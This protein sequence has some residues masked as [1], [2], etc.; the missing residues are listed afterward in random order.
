MLSVTELYSL[1]VTKPYLL[2]VTKPYSLSVTEPYSLSVTELVEVPPQQITSSAK[3]T[4]FIRFFS[5]S[6][7]TDNIP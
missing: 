2:S 3:I 7:K 1:S 6:P 5:Y 4:F